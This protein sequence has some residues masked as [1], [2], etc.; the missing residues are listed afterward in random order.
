MSFLQMGLITL[1]YCYIKFVPRD[2]IITNQGLDRREKK[3]KQKNCQPYSSP[4]KNGEQKNKSVFPNC[5]S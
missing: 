3:K 5:A 1:D 2:E 4:P